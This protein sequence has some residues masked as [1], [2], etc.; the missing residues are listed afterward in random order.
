MREILFRGKRHNGKWIFGALSK[1]DEPYFIRDRKELENEILVH[2]ETVGQYTGLKDKNGTKI[3]EGDVIED[4]CGRV[5]VIIADD[6]NC[7]CCAG[8]YG[9]STNY[10]SPDLRC[11]EECVVIGNIHDNPELLKARR[12]K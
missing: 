12:S 11:Y 7:S 6:W 8:V 5:D 2:P 9:F 10:G 4:E 1:C 3:F